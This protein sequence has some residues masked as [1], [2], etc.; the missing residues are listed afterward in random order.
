MS[1][2]LI[3]E[4]DGT[5]W[6]NRAASRFV[7]AGGLRW[8][9]QVMGQGPGALL[10]HGTGASTHSWAGLAPLLAKQWT[11]VAPDMPGHGFTDMPSREGLTLPGM[12]SRLAALTKAL[13]VNPALA[14]GHS[15]GAAVLI[16]MALD[17]A[18]SPALIVSLNGALLPFGGFAAPIFSPLAKLLFDNSLAPR[19]FALRAKD[20]RA[21][22]RVIRGTGSNVPDAYIDF[23]ARLFRSPVHVA[24]ALGMM[25]NWDLP[26]LVRDLPRLRSRLL[27]VAASMD[28]AVPP[29][30]AFR[31]RDVAPKAVV[32]V[33]RGLGHLAH[34]EDPQAVAAIIQHGAA[35]NRPP[36]AR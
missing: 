30:T 5:D 13:A 19:L 25:A 28:S 20:R 14:V 1:E 35:Q 15:A 36:E 32:E 8:H 3:W 24:A 23:Y 22:E 9:V 7:D 34:E 11:V 33:A 16:R 4:R 12:A 21:V 17:G 29:D 27:L 10:V 26:A 2:R 18:I 31:V 6:P